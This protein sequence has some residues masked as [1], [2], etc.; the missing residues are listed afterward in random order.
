MKKLFLSLLALVA[1]VVTAN[2]Q[3][4]WAYDLSLTSESESYTFTF[5]ATTAATATLILSD[6]EGNNVGTLDLGAV[7]AGSNTFTYTTDQLPKAGKMNWAVKLEA[8]AIANIVEV[9]D[10]SRGIYDFYNMMDVLVDNNPESEYFGK[11]YIQ[12]ALN[13]GSDGS[14]ERAKTQKA[15]LFIYDQN[16]NELNPTSNVGIQ[17]T[18]PEG[19]TMGDNRNKFH[20]LEI[21][22][23]TGKLAY[24]YN[25][26]GSPAVFAID[27]ANLTGAVENLLAGV[28]GLNQTCAH[29]FDA[30]GTLYVMNL[31]SSK[32]TIYKIVDG[33]A[34]PMTEATGK[35]INSSMS[36]AADGM[37][38]LW[39]AQNRGQLDGYYQL[40]HMT[41][42]GVIDWSVYDDLG[43][44]VQNKTPGTSSTGWTGG[45]ARG[46]LAYD[47]ER[48][49]LAQ[50]R[51]GVVEVYSVAYDAETGVPTLTLVASTPTVGTNID[52]LHFDYAGDLYVV[53]SS[54]EKFQKFAMP[55]EN[56]VCTTPAPKAQVLINTDQTVYAITI[57][58]NEE[59]M[60][61]VTGAGN[62]LAGE[63]ATLTA[64]ANAGY[65]FVS[66]T[67]G[68]E[69]KTENPLT[70]TVNSNLTVTANFVVLSQYTITATANDA[71]MGSVTGAGKY[72]EGDTVTLKAVANKGH[73]FVDWSNG[74]TEATLTF[75]ATKDST[76]QANFKVLSYTVALAT[77]DENKGTV[78]GAGTYDYGTEVELTATAAD[79]Y[80]L[81]YWSDRSTENPRT[82]T[83]DGNE[84]LS[85]YFVKTYTQEPTF[86]IEKLWENTNVPSSTNN[87]Y[88][89]VGWDGK[90]YMQDAG[91]SKIM[92]YANGTDA[93]VEY[94]ASGA[95]Q[96]IA[97]DEA[98]NL[99][100]F[101]AYFA[102]ATPNAVL[103]YPKGNTEGKAVSFTLLQ[104]ARCDFFSASGNIYS[105]EG[106]YIYF[107]CNGKTV[108]NRLK[109]TNGAATAADVTTDVVGGSIYATPQN[110]NHVMVDIFGN[111]VTHARS[112]AI[113]SINVLT[114]ECATFTLPSIKMGTLGGCSF[115]LGGKELWA[116]HAGATNYSSEWNIYNMTDKKFL[117]DEVLY[118]VDKANSTNNACNWLNVQKVDEKTAYI[119]Q[120][121]PKK[122]VAAWKVTCDTGEEPGTGTAVDNTTVAPQ[123]QKIIRDG[124]VLIIR[125]GKTFNMMGQEV[126]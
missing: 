101:N 35:F 73:E 95:G 12:M 31:A 96:Q 92:S 113:N 125:D 70:L 93:A 53:N 83:V 61:T 82:I 94:A 88:Q 69:T 74:A 91:N 59:A 109:I 11:I 22:P 47:A 45:A 85:A 60:G 114:N 44:F 6:K 115:E 62:Y 7:V 52:G 78:A 32:G 106:G 102:T 86:T 97:V 10:Q 48:K 58:V 98:G 81:L 17:P 90:I 33:Q 68:E 103:I 100:V 77:N 25:V 42:A 28:E 29:A 19:Y 16:L 80:E 108:I 21:D 39:I 3:R 64:T 89:A 24:C 20:R 99:I 26:A 56:N 27:R 5:K 110:T 49:L 107:Y 57:A 122:G 15:G 37:G 75:V 84:A 120:F 34:V 65:K 116:Y 4:A 13:G 123:V 14:T 54:K 87:G 23:K 8:G 66:W 41:S 124:Q 76:V 117:S 46:A 55:T 119:Y 36:M 72:T 38:G 18:L 30:E 105:A 126:R 67:V 43:T 50:G 2:A 104:P 51:N 111:L 71:T 40:A 63:S 112:N 121:C 1:M 9:T 79:G 118:A